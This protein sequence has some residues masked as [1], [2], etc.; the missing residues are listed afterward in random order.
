MKTHSKKNPWKLSALLVLI[1]LFFIITASK[2]SETVGEKENPKKETLSSN[3]K[4]VELRVEE[5][6]TDLPL[7]TK[8]ETYGKK[9]GLPSD[10]AN[11][12][13]IDGD[14]VLVGTD[15]GLVIYQDQSWKVITTADGLSHNNVLSIDV[16]ELTGDVW[17]ATMSG[18]N[19]W[20]AGKFQIFNQF[21]SGLANDVIYTVICD[22]QYVWTATAAGASRYDSYTN[23][24][25]IFNE[26][27]APMHEPWTY[28]VCNGDDKVYIAA[29]GGGV[30]EYHKKTGHFRDHTDPDHEMEIDL[31]PDDGVVHDITTGVTYANGVLWVGTYFGMSRYDGLRWNS[32]FDHDSGLASNFIN[33]IKADGSVVYVCT[34]NGFSTFNSKRWAT[35]RKQNAG[36]RVIITEGDQTTNIDFPTGLSTNYI[37]GCDV[38]DGDLW[39]ATGYGV[40][41]AKSTGKAELGKQKM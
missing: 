10:K 4:P 22:Q 40:C 38:K 31:F 12:V 19:R 7:Y 17:I 32:Y 16:N 35:Y 37:W 9:D 33:F 26:Q 11:C 1:V 18:L 5:G 34:D 6:D 27:N 8:W 29:W 14:R 28:G 30:I 20:S 2:K 23:Q 25:K 24:W 15:K 13:K 3:K 39:L 41:H 21:N 36:N